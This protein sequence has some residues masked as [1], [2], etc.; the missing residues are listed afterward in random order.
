[1]SKWTFWLACH[2]CSDTLGR[3]SMSTPCPDM[4]WDVL[5]KNSTSIACPDKHLSC[6]DTALYKSE[7]VPF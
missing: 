4:S 5:G 3:E 2:L 7:N 1:M 6:P